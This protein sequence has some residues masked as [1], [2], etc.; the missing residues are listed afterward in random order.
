[1]SIRNTSSS[2]F[3]NFRQWLKKFFQLS[4]ILKFFLNSL[5]NYPPATENT[6]TRTE[7]I[8]NW[9][10]EHIC[11]KFFYRFRIYLWRIFIMSNY[12]DIFRTRELHKGRVNI[13]LHMIDTFNTISPPGLQ[14]IGMENR[15][16]WFLIFFSLNLLSLLL[17]LNFHLSFMFIL[18]IPKLQDLIHVYW[19][20][21]F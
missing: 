16:P 17:C 8:P 10:C 14:N 3:I 4:N 19:A 5:N 13:R 20:F 12:Y 1:M 9:L 2:L 15:I 6:F 21:N 18:T 11:L 7:I